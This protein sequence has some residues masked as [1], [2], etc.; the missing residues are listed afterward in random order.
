MKWKVWAKCAM[1]ERVL[2][3]ERFLAMLWSKVRNGKDASK[4]QM[5]VFRRW[6]ISQL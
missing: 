6:S 2:K 5:K 4:D 3:W 1:G